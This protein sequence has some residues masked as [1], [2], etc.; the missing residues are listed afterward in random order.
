M[1]MYRMNIERIVE[2]SDEAKSFILVPVDKSEGLFNYMPGQFFLLESEITRPK[3]L[4]FDKEKNR[5]IG[6][7]ETET[8]KVKKAFSAVSSPTDDYIELLIKSEGGNF[9]P[10]FLDQVVEGDTCL[11]GPPAGM[12]MKKIFKNSERNIACWS[13]GSG[14]PSTISLMKYVAAKEIDTKIVVLDS[15]KATNEIIFKKRINDMI[16]NSENFSCV[17]ALTREDGELPKPSDKISYINGRFWADG[18][19]LEQYAGDEWKNFFNTVCGSSS[20]I[21]GMSRN[22]KGVPVKLGKG[23]E[24]F[25]TEFGIPKDKI[26]KDQ[27]YLQ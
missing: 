18:N 25:L 11:L 23:I 1:K 26:D 15:N 4:F 9:S 22:D 27:Y 13:A 21:N 24:D 7:E 3:N 16:N 14:I 2:E 17:F 6:S 20:F 10:Y 19:S 8:L 12:F 5:M